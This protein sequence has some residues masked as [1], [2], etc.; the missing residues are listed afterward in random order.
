MERERGRAV[1]NQGDGSIQGGEEGAGGADAGWAVEEVDVWG[2]QAPLAAL[3]VDGAGGAGGEP[4]RVVAGETA[5]GGG[6]PSGGA[7]PTSVEGKVIM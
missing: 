3:P 6:R 7:G 5:G 1:G 2:A 4:H